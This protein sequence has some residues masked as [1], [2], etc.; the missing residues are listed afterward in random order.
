MIHET[1]DER[2]N[3]LGSHFA[4]GLHNFAQ[5]VDPVKEMGG[6]QWT[7]RLS[8]QT[9]S[10]SLALI[11]ILEFLLTPLPCASA[12][13]D[14]SLVDT[15]GVWLSDRLLS[16]NIAQYIVCIYVLVAGIQFSQYVIEE[17]S[18]ED[19]KTY[20]HN[21]TEQF[22]DPDLTQST[23]DLFMSNLNGYMATYLQSSN[24][25]CTPEDILTVEEVESLCDVNTGF[26]ACEANSTTQ[27]LCTFA[28]ALSDNQTLYD[29]EH[30]LALLAGA[31]FNVTGLEQSA[32]DALE[33][34]ADASVDSLY[35]SHEY[36]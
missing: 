32:I 10:F 23:V 3:I 35:P 33:E 31:G 17:Y 29:I 8:K 26:Y 12:V 24:D 27:Y 5:H 20:I 22:F 13:T 7:W 25:S 34:A 9:G 36:M 2:S 11:L 4:N 14:N 30:Q 15:Y 6:F 28:H 21:I 19:A 16:G 1:V 18:K